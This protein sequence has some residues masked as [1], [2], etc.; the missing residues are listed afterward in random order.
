MLSTLSPRHRLAAC[1][2]IGVLQLPLL[3]AQAEPVTIS[4]AGYWLET[5]GS[6]SLGLPGS[7]SGTPT[8]LFVGN[9]S[10][11]AGTTASASINGN[12]VT[13]PALVD[14]L[15][16]RRI[17]EPNLFQQQALSVTFSNGNDTASFTG[18]SLLGLTPLPLAGAL[19]VDGTADAFGPLISWT[20]PTGEDVDRVQLVFYDT[21]SQS[22]IGSRITLA[23]STTS[24]DLAGPLPAGLGLTINVR[25]IDLADDGA[26]FEAG[27]VLRSSRAYIDY[28]VPAVPE[29]SSLLLMALGLAGLAGLGLRRRVT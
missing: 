27:N 25:L 29:P 22:E 20:L 26:A 28:A 16:V 12:A 7:A 4:N 23:G 18:Q 9:T 21:A 14:G 5:L 11:L 17:V 10:P 6:N 15:W 1:L 3:S 19:A 2:A 13:P 24:F 8:T